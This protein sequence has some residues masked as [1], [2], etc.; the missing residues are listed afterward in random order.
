[1]VETAPGGTPTWVSSV[2]IARL[3]AGDGFFGPEQGAKV[4]ANCVVGTFYGDAAVQRQDQRS[5][6]MT[7]DGH[8][9][10]IIESHLTFDI[11]EIKTKGETM[12]IVVVNTSSDEAGLFYASIPDTSPQFLAPS[13][14]ALAEL[15]VAG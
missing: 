13:R 5:E 1:L 10:W 8:Q 14:R 4:V 6:A 9:A 3:L 2:L 11:P 7:V 12:I 15:K